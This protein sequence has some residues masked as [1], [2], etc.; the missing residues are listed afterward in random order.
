MSTMPQDEREL[1]IDHLAARAGMTVRTVRSHVTRRLLPPPRLVEPL[2][3]D[4]VRIVTPA[5]FRAGVQV[6]RLGMPAARVIEVEPAIRPHLRAVAEA[7][8]ELFRE[9]VWRGLVEAGMPAEP[10][11]RAADTI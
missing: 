8:V 6:I 1:T 4:R 5:L 3:G 11:E 2:E 9:G 10:V 7:F